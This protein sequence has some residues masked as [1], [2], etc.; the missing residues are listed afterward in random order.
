MKLFDIFTQGPN[1]TIHGSTRAKN[2]IGA[3]FSLFVLSVL[4]FMTINS[5][6]TLFKKN[7][8][9][10]ITNND[11]LNEFD[12]NSSTKN[13]TF[14]SFRLEDTNEL[15]IEDEDKLISYNI[16]KVKYITDSDEHGIYRNQISNSSID[17]DYCDQ[18]KFNEP[19]KFYNKNMTKYKCIKNLKGDMV[20]MQHIKTYINIKIRLCN[21]NTDFNITSKQ[22][23]TDCYS[24]DKQLEIFRQKQFIFILN[25]IEHKID[26]KDYNVPIKHSLEKLYW[27]IDT[28]LYFRSELFFK[29]LKVQT[30]IGLI[31]QSIVNHIGKQ[32]DSEKNYLR[33]RNQTSSTLVDI[34]LFFN[35]DASIVERSYYKV[36]TM[37][38]ELGSF[39]S[40]CFN[41]VSLGLLPLKDKLISC[42]IMSELYDFHIDDSSIKKRISRKSIGDFI[43]KN[44]VN[45]NKPKVSLKSNRVSQ[46]IE[47]D[48]LKDDLKLPPT[49]INIEKNNQDSHVNFK[50]QTT[51]QNTIEL[52]FKDLIN[53]QLNSNIDPNNS[54]KLI[55]KEVEQV[56]QQQIEKSP[57]IK[58]PNIKDDSVNLELKKSKE[59]DLNLNI[60]ELIDFQELKIFSNFNNNKEINSIVNKIQSLSKSIYSKKNKLSRIRFN[61]VELF[62]SVYCCNLCKPKKVETLDKFYKKCYKEMKEYLDINVITRKLKEI[63]SLKLLTCNQEQILCF[64][65]FVK[66]E[67]D[68][69]NSYRYSS[70]IHSQ[71][72]NT[73]DSDK[74]KQ[75]INY[76]LHKSKG[77]DDFL[78]SKIIEMLDEELVE[79][80]NTTI[81]LSHKAN[82][83]TCV[84]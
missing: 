15:Y 31:N 33:S 46:I 81:E 49:N 21:N 1:L 27:F 23:K 6:I 76:F 38:A 12:L 51:H 66:P 32:L 77:K 69:N 64:N 28:N 4:L 22:P 30:D 73:P 41:I 13:S 52:S 29:Y 72:K 61:S 82:L 78:D 65:Y 56:Q 18:V 35:S 3:I 62:L 67:I 40:I 16:T 24:R 84:N 8:I 26:I 25:K 19:E 75:I 34:G 80:I 58:E 36:I 74:L 70:K 2:N 60:N 50:N 39:F 11:L 63:E 48:S 47:K 43:L 44:I 68:E 17:Y 55:E 7:R 42:E 5:L 59:L 20:S 9:S 14:I 83:E 57:T 54:S 79:L 45:L 37:I 71:Y 53:N 10:V